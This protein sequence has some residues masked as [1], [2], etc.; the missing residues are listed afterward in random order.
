MG[1][2]GEKQVRVTAGDFM[3]LDSIWQ[4]GEKVKKPLGSA[5]QAAKAGFASWLDEPDAESYV[6]H[7]KTKK[8]IPLKWVNGVYKMQAW[9]KSPGFTRQGK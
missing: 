7:K 8:K 9:V 1:N 3:E 6:I 5:G 4:I 2:Q